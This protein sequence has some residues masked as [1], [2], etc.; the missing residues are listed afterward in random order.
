[1][2]QY[3]V[4][5]SSAGGK[6]GPRGSNSGNKEDFHRH[7]VEL[8]DWKSRVRKQRQELEEKT[9]GLIECREE[10]KYCKGIMTKLKEENQELMIKARVAETLR[11]ELDAAVERA[12]KADRL[13]SEVARYRE[14]LTDIEYYK[15]RI[16]ELRE[17]N[18][19]LLETR[20]MLE[21]QLQLSR[22]K[23]EKVL[24]L[25]SEI[26]KYE[27]LFNDMALEKTSEE[28][29]YQ[30]VCDENSQLHS[31]IKTMASELAGNNSFFKGSI[32]EMEDD[33][34]ADKLFGSGD[35]R[36][37]EQLSNNAQTRA[38]K[39]ELENRRLATLIDSLKEKSSHEYS[40][41]VLEL[42][43]DKK[44]LSLKVKA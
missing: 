4:C 30:K 8:A 38:L 14:K 5:A 40:F 44:K 11:D 34:F 31:L 6:L 12:E 33:S 22:E 25:E 26:V 35:N 9:E 20:E 37:S 17:D 27:K 36:L 24:E 28:S 16:D 7:V 1:M 21:E 23:A 10:L 18:K 41:Q 32:T 15:S 19:V 43:K 39:L 3:Y 42:E 2:L 13:E 29:K